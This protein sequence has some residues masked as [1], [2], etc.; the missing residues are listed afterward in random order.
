MKKIIASALTIFLIAVSYCQQ[1]AY[2]FEGSGDE[3]NV[4]NLHPWLPQKI[5]DYSGIYHFGESESEWDLLVIVQ[6]S[7]LVFEAFKN[8]W[9]KADNFK[10]ETWVKYAEVYRKIKITQN[11]FTSDSLNG[12]FMS[13]ETKEYKKK[14]IILPNDM[15]KI[16]SA[17]FGSK[18]PDELKSFWFFDGEYPELSYMILNDSFFQDKTKDEL[19]IM[20]NEIYARYGKRFVK[21][22]KMYNYFSK[23]KWYNPYRDDVEICL[24]EI[25][26]RNLSKIKKFEKG[27]ME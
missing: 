22:G 1:P 15:N 5:S 18:D 19:Q 7:F 4:K 11:K 26:K 27:E 13:Y 24:T 23:K 10:A 14:G 25:E 16:D 6:D 3:L 8:E 17:E 2:L 9:A 21:N 12:F 20:R